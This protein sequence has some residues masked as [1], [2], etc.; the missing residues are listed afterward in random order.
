M[1]HMNYKAKKKSSFCYF[2]YLEIF[3]IKERYFL[4]LI[5]ST[6][7]KCVA[8]IQITSSVCFFTKFF[9]LVPG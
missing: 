4:Q 5:L 2:K 9:L 3:S 1:D 7:E 8:F 6:A